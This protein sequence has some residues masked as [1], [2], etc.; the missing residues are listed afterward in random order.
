MDKFFLLPYVRNKFNTNE[1]INEVKQF[2]RFKTW[3]IVKEETIGDRGILLHVKKSGFVGFI[4]VTLEGGEYYV[5]K[6][7]KCGMVLMTNHTK[8][9]SILNT[10]FDL[11]LAD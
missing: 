10:I 9:L 4:L 7:N 2:N 3:N 8:F 1:L 11:Y 6:V 5:R